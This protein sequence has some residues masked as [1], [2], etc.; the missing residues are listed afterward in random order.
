MK[1]KQRMP[2][3]NQPYAKQI[4]A[5]FLCF[6]LFP[7]N[8]PAMAV[9]K[10]ANN[11]TVKA[12][13][14]FFDGYHM[15]DSDGNYSGYGIELLNLI[16]QYSH[17]NF[18]FV[19]YDNTWEEMQSMLLNGEID[20]VTS[21][22]KTRARSEI[23][24]FSDP[25]ERNS[26]VLS[27]L[28]ENTSIIPGDYST[29]DGM[30][31][32]LLSGSSQNRTLPIFAEENGF[33]YQTRE[34]EDSDKLEI[35]LQSGE[36]DA[37]LTSNLR[38]TENEKTLDTTDIDY[39]YAITRK[40]DQELLDEINYALSQMNLHEGNYWANTLY[41]KYYGT[42]VSYVHN[43]SFTQ[44]EL[45]Y[46]QA[47]VSGEK[48]I[49]ITSM[50]G[51]RPYSYAEDGELKGIQPR[52]FDSL[53]KIAGLPYEMIVPEDN[54]EYERLK[55]SGSVDVVIDWQQSAP[56]ETEY[57]RDGF[58]TSTYMNTG[59]TLVTR[60]DFTGSVSSLAVL[61]GLVGMPLEYE[62]FKNARILSCSSQDEVVQAVLDGKTDAAFMRTHA[63]QYFVN[64][65]HTNS[66]QFDIL[67]SEQIVFNMYIPNS[68][69][70]ELVTILNKCIQLVPDDVLTRL[71][72]EYTADTLENVAFFQYMSAHPGMILILSSIAALAV[73]VILF[74]YLRSRWNNKLLRT[75]EQAKQELEVQLAIVNA[76][77][78]DYF[79]V[80]K[81]DTHAGTLQA[82]K[83]GGYMHTGMNRTVGTVFSYNET[84]QQYMDTSQ[85]LDEDKDDLEQA[86]SLERIKEKLSSSPEYMGTLDS[87]SGETVPGLISI[88]TSVF[89]AS[90]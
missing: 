57:T 64:N 12:G 14:F 56:T 32:G 49:T 40:D 8:I 33:T 53:M 16:S 58:L 80:Y 42:G 68:S 18:E 36:I 51:R 9:E 6:M 47:V 43:V 85:V 2:L 60:K 37:I 23:F 34:Y 29:Y 78:R 83:I 46:I 1:R 4:F 20:V 3:F 74:F 38:R 86:F 39:F 24:G 59:T 70:H 71:I 81:L 13:V 21:A 7:S 87:F 44:R 45:D 25:I 30:T 88:V 73:G 72:A 11:R 82:L 41:S 54:A 77:S 62:Q 10:P 35:A 27:I 61:D 17:L 55:E 66:L 63:A 89:S 75:T 76:L 19:G 26:T 67:D 48:H 79:T 69:D 22:R 84:L 15:Q 5:L 52:F 50:P 65:D 31:V 28:E 90:R